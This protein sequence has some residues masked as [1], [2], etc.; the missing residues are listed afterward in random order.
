MDTIDVVVIGAG[1]AGIATS[2][3]LSLRGVDH[4]VLEAERPGFTWSRRWESFTLVTPNHS[5]RLPGAGYAGDDP[6]GFLPRDDIE[7]HIRSYAAGLAAEVRSGV[8][9]DRLMTDHHGGFVLDTT[10]EPI[11]ARSVVV[12]TGA[13]QEPFRPAAVAE[14]PPGPVVVD[15]IDYRRPDA[16][17]EGAVL[18]V[19]GGQ[20]ACQVA[21]ELVLAGREVV[22]AAGR[23]PW[24]HRRV[25]GRDIVDWML[26]AG[27]FDDAPDTLPSPAARLFANVQASGTR[28]GHDLNYRVLAGLG[29]RLGGRLVG[30]RDGQIRLGDDLQ[31]SI[32]FGDARQRMF[33]DELQAWVTTTGRGPLDRSD[34]AP[35]TPSPVTSVPL[36]G[37]GAVVVA[38]GY[39]TRYAQWIEVPELVDGDGFPVHVDGESTVA[40]GLHFVG[41]HFLRTRGSSLLLGVGRDAAA[42]ADR[43]AARIPST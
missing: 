15:A 40:P 17:P 12:A 42:T 43:I 29:V 2:H 22:V 33:M 9:V 20:S 3:E 37:L 23:A 36:A 1:Q 26:D 8:R 6:N 16:L 21:E 30:A 34:P 38:A 32:E 4:V 7:A 10:D 13:Y 24:V 19:G 39:R 5:I 31:A 28:G 27:F 14:I 18:V 25:E 35:F 41:V 11:S